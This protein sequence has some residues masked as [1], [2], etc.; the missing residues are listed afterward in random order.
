MANFL[1]VTSEA[2]IHADIVIKELQKSNIRPIRLNSESFIQKSQYFYEWQASGNP[3]QSFLSFESSLREVQDV[4]VI[5]W[6]KPQDYQVFPEVNNEWA[7]KY[8]QQET[9]SLIYSL[10]GLY[11]K[12]RW[13]NHY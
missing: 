12:A 7:I 4:G 8:C 10:S 13:V 11:P 5:W 9:E 2:D 6:R 1:I 3:R